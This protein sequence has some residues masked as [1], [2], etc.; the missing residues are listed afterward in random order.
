MFFQIKQRKVLQN[1]SILRE[2]NMASST[3][4]YQLGPIHL[5]FPGSEAGFRWDTLKNVSNGFHSGV[6]ENNRA[7]VVSF[8]LLQLY[9]LFI[10][11]LYVPDTYLFHSFPTN[12]C[13]GARKRDVNGPYYFVASPWLL[14]C[15][16]VNSN[17]GYLTTVN[18]DSHCHP[19][20]QVQ[21]FG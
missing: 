1:H 21:Q 5:M 16:E 6:L 3:E 15:P 20:G 18:T 17:L 4:E 12:T 9:F 14:L 8:R 7:N 10:Y 11:I 19:I 2:K 13:I